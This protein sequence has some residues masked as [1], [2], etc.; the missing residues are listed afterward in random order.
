MKIFGWSIWGNSRKFTNE[1]KKDISWPSIVGHVFRVLEFDRAGTTI[2]SSGR[3][4]PVDDFSPYGYLLVESPVYQIPFK[5]PIVH[6]DDFFLATTFFDDP[7]ILRQFKDMDLLVTYI[8]EHKTADGRIGIRH[9]LHYNVTLKGVLERYY[10]NESHL[11]HP[12]PKKIF[13][14]FIYHGEIKIGTNL[15]PTL[16]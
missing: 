16:Y 9:A 4:I 3:I 11:S 1:K 10:N 14:E 15:N 6:R 12:E 5:L 7:E 13:G 8:P 2:D